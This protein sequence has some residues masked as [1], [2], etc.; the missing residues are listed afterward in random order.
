MPKKVGSITSNTGKWVEGERVADGSVVAM[1]RG[2]A[3]GAG[4]RSTTKD[5]KKPPDPKVRAPALDPTCAAAVG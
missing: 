4:L 5:V 2:N 1:N 3:W